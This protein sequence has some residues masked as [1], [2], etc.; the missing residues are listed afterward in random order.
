MAQRTLVV[1]PTKDAVAQAGAQ[2]LLLAIADLLGER[3]DG[4]KTR[5]RVDVA[6]TGGSATLKALEYMASNPLTDTI[7]WTRVHLWW[8]DERF[9]L[10]LIHI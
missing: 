1:Y 8:A 7:D 4:G 5:N 3:L 2:R 10:S 6:L 9:V